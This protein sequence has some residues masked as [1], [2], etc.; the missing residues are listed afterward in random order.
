MPDV[1]VTIPNGAGP[2]QPGL[3]L[4]RALGKRFPGEG[5][6]DPPNYILFVNETGDV[7]CFL[8]TGSTMIND[9]KL[10]DLGDGRDGRV[11]GHRRCVIEIT[12]DGK[13]TYLSPPEQK[14]PP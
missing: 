14:S 3:T 5:I 6:H 7:V 4:F 12:P 10:M 1:S 2:M 8:P 13:L 11:H 9:V